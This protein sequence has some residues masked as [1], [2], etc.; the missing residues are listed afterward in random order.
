MNE[1]EQLNAQVAKLLGWTV[2]AT[3]AGRLQWIDEGGINWGLNTPDYLGDP[4]LWAPL[5]ER[6]I[7]A[8]WHLRRAGDHIR[9][10]RSMEEPHG[11]GDTLAEAVCRLFVAL[12]GKP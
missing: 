10:V 7:E 3:P 8:R 9:L 2:S 11:E 5:L 1:R 4:R 6:F 12:E